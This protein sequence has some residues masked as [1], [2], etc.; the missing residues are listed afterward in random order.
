MKKNI[1]IVFGLA[2]LGLNTGCSLEP[3]LADRDDTSVT[4]ESKMRQI[5]DGSYSQMVDYRFF[6]RNTIIAGEIRSDNM[7]SNNQSNRFGAMS[8]MNLTESSGDVSDLFKYGYRGISNANTLINSDFESAEG[9]IANKHHIIGEA[10]T[11]RALLHFELLKLF[12]QQYVA[13]GSDLGITYTKEFKAEDLALPRGSVADNKA[14]LYSD[15]E[16]AIEH[17]TLGESS[18]YA[19]SKIKLTLDA[20]YA[21]KSRMGI[22]F[23]DYSAALA[24]SEKIVDSYVITPEDE[25]VEYW[26][27][28]NPGKASIF[29]LYRD[30]TESD[31]NNSISNIYNAGSYGDVVA[32]R[33]LIVDAGFEPDDVRASAAMI[34]DTIDGNLRNIGK[35]GTIGED[36]GSDNIKMFRIEEVVLNHAEALHETNPGEALTYLNMITEARGATAYTAATLDNIL[37]ERRKELMFEGHRFH[38]LARTGNDIQQPDDNIPWAHG[39]VPS[40][41]NKFAMPIPRA[42]INANPNTV[43]NPGY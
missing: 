10:Y 37:K 2:L 11:T 41:D 31:G 26:S 5:M 38:D 35:Y 39:L 36:M 9:D 1:I 32:F 6:G 34:T 8:Q 3:T 7:Y 18:E 23:N 14:D 29:E 42:E 22:Y 20:A 33:N 30:G 27:N 16:K 24:A 19:N 28:S 43:Q 15:I 13:A 17:F 40:G 12:G 21:L 25:V 4:L